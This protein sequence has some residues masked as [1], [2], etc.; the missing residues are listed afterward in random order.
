MNLAKK[1]DVS[2]ELKSK[3]QKLIWKRYSYKKW[4]L[5]TLSLAFTAQWLTMVVLWCTID[6]DEVQGNYSG[7][8]TVVGQRGCRPVL[9]LSIE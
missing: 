8:V 5:G 3:E 2:L 6:S 9:L 1:Q 4:F 7:G